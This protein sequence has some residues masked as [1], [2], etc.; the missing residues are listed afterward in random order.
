MEAKRVG[1]TCFTIDDVL[2]HNER[3]YKGQGG[4]GSSSGSQDKD[5]LCADTAA[6]ALTLLRQQGGIFSRLPARPASAP[7][8]AEAL[9]ARPPCRFEVFPQ[10][11]ASR[12]VDVVLDIAHNPAAVAAVAAKV[13]LHYPAQP[14]R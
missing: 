12:Q 13:R 5:L 8:L 7:E 9:K 4:P 11:G 14:V 1:A 10:Q 2:F 6:A 3:R